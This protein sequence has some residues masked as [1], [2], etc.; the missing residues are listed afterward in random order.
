MGKATMDID[1]INNS[2]STRFVELLGGIFEH[3][4]WVAERVYCA[5][6]FASRA[7]LHGKMVAEVR[8]AS[9]EQRRA[10]P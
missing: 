1:Q 9:T 4:P 7:E 3:S 6:P 8:K 5:R 2:D 10:L